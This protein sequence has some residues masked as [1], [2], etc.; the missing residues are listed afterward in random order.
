MLLVRGDALVEMGDEYE[1]LFDY[2]AITRT[3]SGSRAFVTALEREYQIAVAYADGLRSGSSSARSASSTPIGR[4]PGTPDSDSGA[5]SRKPPRRG[6]RHESSRTSTSYDSQMR[7]AADAYDLFVQNYPRIRPH[8]E[9]A[10]TAHPGLSRVLPRPALRRHRSPRRQAP[11]RAPP[12]SPNP[13][14][15]SGSAPRPCSFAS[16]NPRLESSSPPPSGTSPSTTRSPPS[17]T[18]AAWSNC[19]PATVAALDALRIWP[20]AI[21]ARTCPRGIAAECT[22]LPRD[23]RSPPRS[24]RDRTRPASR[25]APRVPLPDHQSRSRRRSP[26][27]PRRRRRPAP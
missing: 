26:S 13:A 23:G 16:R 17:S 8:R 22:R 9:G 6:R 5:P 4:R 7:L 2:E 24:R 25:P 19:I 21:L 14:S 18:S 20:P 12:R 27:T 3:Y 15:P 1:A 10:A 11:T